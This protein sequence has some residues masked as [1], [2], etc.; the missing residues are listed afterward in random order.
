MLIDADHIVQTTTTTTS[1][2]DES[3]NSD[4]LKSVLKEYGAIIIKIADGK[5]GRESLNPFLDSLSHYISM[6]KND[7]G[8]ALMIGEDVT[9]D[10]YQLAANYSNTNKG[11]QNRLLVEKP[12]LNSLG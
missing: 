1:T 8:L 10:A 7:I 12:M 4:D 6:S 9:Q 2:K 11:I 5:I 3:K